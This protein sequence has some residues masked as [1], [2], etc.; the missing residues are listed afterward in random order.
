[1]PHPRR[2][3]DST[4]EISLAERTRRGI[5]PTTART[6][7]AD[8]LVD[9]GQPPPD[10][11]AD[12]PARVAAVSTILSRPPSRASNGLVESMRM[13]PWGHLPVARSE[14]AAVAWLVRALASQGDCLRSGQIVLSGG[15][16][17]AVPVSAGD[18]V[19]A[20]ISRLGSIGLACA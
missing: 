20:S 7:I 19:I 16:T 2:Q 10:A 18:S 4:T 5:R 13:R 17:A 8:A 14:K 11:D 15:L 9:A 3:H 12:A 1:V 6:D